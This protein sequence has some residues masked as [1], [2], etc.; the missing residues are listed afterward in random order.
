[1]GG[2]AIGISAGDAH[3]SVHMG[4]GSRAQDETN[5]LTTAIAQRGNDL[6]GHFGMRLCHK[7]ER[8]GWERAGGRSGLGH[9]A[10][11]HLQTSAASISRDGCAGHAARTSPRRFCS[12][13]TVLLTCLSFWSA[14][15]EATKDERKVAQGVIDSSVIEPGRRQGRLLSC[16]HGLSVR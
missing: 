4:S 9:S 8:K 7:E 12:S 16:Q 6:V 13:L 3:C 14:V 5:A 15:C 10:H 2:Q 1:M 11:S